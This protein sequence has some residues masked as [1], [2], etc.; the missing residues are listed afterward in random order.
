MGIILLL[1]TLIMSSFK[2]YLYIVVEEHMPKSL[3][4]QN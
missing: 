2:T 4:S 1:Y 3:I